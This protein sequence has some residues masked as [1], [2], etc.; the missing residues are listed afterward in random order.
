MRYHTA[1]AISVLSAVVS[2]IAGTTVVAGQVLARSEDEPPPASVEDFKA[3]V[4]HHPDL[5]AVELAK[6]S[7]SRLVV[8]EQSLISFLKM[9]AHSYFA[10]HRHKAEQ[11]MIVMDG[12]CDEIIEGK[13]YRVRKGDVVIL[14]SN[15]EHGAY[16]RDEDCIVIDVFGEVRGDYL[17]KMQQAMA[18]KGP[19]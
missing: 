12:Y 2:F 10:P 5:P 4:L 15:I 19:K 17:M 6:G 7:H 18:S 3:H 11:I 13:L 8:G 1:M 9:E 16:I 14:P